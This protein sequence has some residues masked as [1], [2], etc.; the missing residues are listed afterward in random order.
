MSESKIN[1]PERDLLALMKPFRSYE[2]A[3]TK[4]NSEAREL[5]SFVEHIIS[6]DQSES[7]N[8]ELWHEYLNITGRSEFLTRL[9]SPEV[10]SQWA[11][12]MFHIVDASQY[13]LLK[14]MEQRV[15]EHPERH[16]FRE[17]D[18]QLSL[19]SYRQVFAYMKKIAAAFYS[20]VEQP[21]VLLYLDNSPEGA[22]ADLACLTF[23]I[24]DSPIDKHFDQDTIAYIV[25]TLGINIVVTD[26]EARLHRMT[27]KTAF[28]E[29]TIFISVKHA[30][31]FPPGRPTQ[32]WLNNRHEARTPSAPS[33]LHP[34]A[35]ENPRVL[36]LPTITS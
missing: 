20:A 17:L 27:L 33:C 10:C 19:W 12:H 26:T 32:S 3:N 14:L 24:L 13:T 21:R 34:A 16:L 35:R 23:G 18:K 31:A 29:T 6:S 22:C 36:R 30:H 4:L 9:D 8:P 7:I 2:A 28:Y 15:G 5:L 1:K 11:D 25:K